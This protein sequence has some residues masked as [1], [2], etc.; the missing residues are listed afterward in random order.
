MGDEVAG[1]SHL[2]RSCEF[3]RLVD[4]NAAK[5]LFKSHSSAQLSKTAGD[6]YQLPESAFDPLQ[7]LGNQP[8]RI[9]GYADSSPTTYVVTDSWPRGPLQ[10]TT[11]VGTYSNHDLDAYWAKYPDSHAA[12][13]ACSRS[14]PTPPG[15]DSLGADRVR[16]PFLGDSALGRM[17]SAYRL[18]ERVRDPRAQVSSPFREGYHHTQGPSP[19]SRSNSNSDRSDIQNLIEAMHVM[20][21]QISRRNAAPL[22]KEDL[23]SG[24]PITYRRFVKHFDAYTARGVV[25]M[26]ERLDLL[27]SSCTGEA[28][29]NISDCIMARSP[30]LGYFEARRILKSLYGQDHTV[31]SA[32]VNKLI[33]GPLLKSN[34]HSGLS[35][36]SRDMRNC[37]MA[38]NNLDSA[39]LDT[40]QTVSGI[41]KRLPNHLQDKFIASVSSHL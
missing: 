22:S 33:E 28:R 14:V 36:L 32:Y 39:G 40:Q 37:L 1:P 9:E 31:V 6:P 2:D 17:G 5:G 21:C 10:P 8:P 7:F 35:A 19:T 15:F 41:F 24:D 27:I 34:D 12:R 3:T 29:A 11:S 16:Q 30:E 26:A 23:F 25:D 4:S 18:G 38:C 13:I 20:T